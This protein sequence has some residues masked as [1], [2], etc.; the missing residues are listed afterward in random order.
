MAGVESVIPMDESSKRWCASERSSARPARNRRGGL[1]TT[2]RDVDRRSPE[3][4]KDQ[5]RAERFCERERAAQE[6]KE[7]VQ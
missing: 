3:K 7:S 5:R 2:A 4:W 1:A 6:R